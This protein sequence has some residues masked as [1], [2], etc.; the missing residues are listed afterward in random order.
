MQSAAIAVLERIQRRTQ[1]SLGDQV[2]SWL[3]SNRLSMLR[4]GRAYMSDEIGLDASPMRA[5]LLGSEGIRQQWGSLEKLATAVGREVATDH[6]NAWLSGA[7]LRIRR[8]AQNKSQPDPWF[9]IGGKVAA[10]AVA[11]K[12]VLTRATSYR[13]ELANDAQ[14]LLEMFERADAQLS[15]KRLLADTS[16]QV[17]DT[18]LSEHLERL[19]AGERNRIEAAFDAGKTERRNEVFA[20]VLGIHAALVDPNAW[21]EAGCADNVLDAYDVYCA[22]V[23]WPDDDV[24]QKRFALAVEMRATGNVVDPHV[25]AY[26]C[27]ADAIMS[28]VGSRPWVAEL[29]GLRENV[30][31]VRT[32]PEVIEEALHERTRFTTNSIIALGKRSLERSNLRKDDPHIATASSDELHSAGLAALDRHAMGVPLD[33]L[34]AMFEG[35]RYLARLVG[36]EEPRVAAHFGLPSAEVQRWAEDVFSVTDTPSERDSGRAIGGR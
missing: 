34:A 10:A 20:H 3:A 28:E 33:E 35:T 32:F 23:A 31:G 17:V 7:L 5:R 25:R 21:S 24:A 14:C 9:Y 36:A 6:F 11:V 19:P 26:A 30:R 16:A 18:A 13:D 22:K 29:A 8:D 15:N 27:R 12:H 1:V 4:R 2:P